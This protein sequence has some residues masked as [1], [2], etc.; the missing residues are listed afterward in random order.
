MRIVFMGSPEIAIPS[1]K[2]IVADGK[3]EVVAVVTQ[4]DRRKGENVF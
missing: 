3:D 1:L 4:P 2:K